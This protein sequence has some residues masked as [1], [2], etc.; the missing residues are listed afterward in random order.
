MQA[1]KIRIAIA[2]GEYS[3]DELAYNLIKSLKKKYPDVEFEFEGIT[4]PKMESIGVKPIYSINKFNVMGFFSVIPK[5]P[6][7]LLIRKNILKRWTK[8]N[9]PDLFIGIDNQDFNLSLYK[10]LKKANIKTIQFVS[11]SVWA[12]RSGRI[13]TI[14]K[15]VDLVLSILPFERNF[16]LKHN[17]RIC[18]VGHPLADSIEVVEQESKV[19]AANDFLIKNSLPKN[20]YKIIGLLP[21]SRVGEI[22]NHLPVMIESANKLAEFDSVNKYIFVIPF[23][24]EK[25]KKIISDFLKTNS[26]HKN[27]KILVKDK[28]D[29]DYRAFEAAVAASGTATLE[30]M[31]YNVPMVVIYK[32]SFIT[33]NIIKYLVKTK[34]I[35]LPNLIAGKKIVTELIQYNA[36]SENILKELNN[37][38]KENNNRNIRKKFRLYHKNMML[39]AMDRASSGVMRIIEV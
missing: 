26:S 15:Y 4:G 34:F 27:I 28:R 2:A 33:F 16:Y 19:Y 35:S 31:I 22:K 29:I 9:K 23:I 3:G 14:K 5:L 24:S 17:A 10:H 20:S 25:H 1:K 18:F 38:I 21:G 12:W 6:N 36:T 37:I 39:G 8:I 30:L 11:P 13:H 7:I 32:M